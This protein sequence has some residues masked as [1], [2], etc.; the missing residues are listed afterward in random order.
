MDLYQILVLIAAFCVPIFSI[1]G[2]YISVKVAI[3]KLQVEIEN[4]KCKLSELTIR[5][6]NLIELKNE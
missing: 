1:V 2:V 5:I 4:I 6:D 3:A